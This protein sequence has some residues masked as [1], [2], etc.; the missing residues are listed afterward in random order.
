MIRNMVFFLQCSSVSVFEVVIGI[1]IPPIVQIKCWD[2]FY[3]GK[4]L[5]RGNCISKTKTRKNKILPWISFARKDSYGPWD[6]L[7]RFLSKS[8]FESIEPL[9]LKIIIT[10]TKF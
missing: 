2:N 9:N 6:T 8:K 7:N 1:T 5:K 10:F 3:V 4:H